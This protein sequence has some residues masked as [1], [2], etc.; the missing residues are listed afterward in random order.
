MARKEEEGV[1]AAC[2]AFFLIENASGFT[3]LPFFPYFSM[4]SFSQY[5]LNACYMPGTVPRDEDTT[6]NRTDKFYPH[7][8]HVLTEGDGQLTV[9]MMC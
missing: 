4:Y 7:G 5:L 8:T 9:R 1:A 6:K 2:W 3:F